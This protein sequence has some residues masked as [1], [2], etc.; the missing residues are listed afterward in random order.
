VRANPAPHCSCPDHTPTSQPAL[1]DGPV[2]ATNSRRELR[3]ATSGLLCNI[4]HLSETSHEAMPRPDHGVQLAAI[5]ISSEPNGS[6]GSGRN[7][8]CTSRQQSSLDSP[9]CLCAFLDDQALCDS[10]RRITSTRIPGL[11]GV[12]FG[13]HRANAVSF[14]CY[15]NYTKTVFTCFSSSRGNCNPAWRLLT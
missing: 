13:S 10:P 6:V 15:I 4:H 11:A 1:A 2:A 7:G 8:C 5:S 3:T 14:R 9:A 12:L